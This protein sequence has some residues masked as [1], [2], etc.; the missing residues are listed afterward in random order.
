MS[1]ESPTIQPQRCQLA[2]YGR[3]DWVVTVEEGTTLDQVLEPGFWS[4]VSVKFKA[5]DHIE[6]RS[7]DGAWF[8]QLIV[9]DCSRNWARV[10][11]T[12]YHALTT[13]DVSISQ[14]EQPKFYTK[15]KGPI[16]KWCVI[17]TSDN[18]IISKEHINA[19]V[20]RESM[21]NYEKVTT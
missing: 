19:D 13:K 14:T 4:M 3:Q 12:A 1:K 10:Y 5:Y 17:R 6:V 18:E 9:L 7:E 15:F 16:L 2:E 20:A 8:A 21:V 11:K